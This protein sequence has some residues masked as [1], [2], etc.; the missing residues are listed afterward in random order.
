MECLVPGDVESGR[1]VARNPNSTHIR[2]YRPDARRNYPA[3]PPP[4]KRRPDSQPTSSLRVRLVP[5]N[6]KG[7]EQYWRLK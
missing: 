4:M 6:R 3:P 2:R 7:F 5:Y 1:S